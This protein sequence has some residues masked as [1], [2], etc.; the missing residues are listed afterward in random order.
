MNSRATVAIAMVV[1]EL[2]TNAAK[3]GALSQPE[4]RVRLEWSITDGTPPA[5]RIRWEEQAARWFIRRRGKALVQ[6]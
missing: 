1:N 4:G 6:A 3:Y 2:L 5:L